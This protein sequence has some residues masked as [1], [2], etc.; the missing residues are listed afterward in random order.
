MLTYDISEKGHHPL[1]LY[2]YD[3][4]KSDIESGVLA[5]NE[6]LPSKRELAEHLGV[7]TITVQNAYAQ[8]LSEGHIYS[9][10]RSGY[11][12]SELEA[13]P[14]CAP[15][16]API[17]DDIIEPV[18]TST[19]EFLVDFCENSISAENFPFAVWATKMREVLS[20]QD[21]QLLKKIP[22][23]GVYNLRRAIADFLRRWRGMNLS[24]EQ[25]IIG[26]GT[27][28]LYGLLI[29][30][31][32]KDCTYAVEDPGYPTI[33][34]IYR[35]E[36]VECRFI[37][38]DESG[39][40]T[41]ALYSSDA[42]IVHISP[43]HHFPTGIVM[44][45][46]RRQEILK[47]ACNKQGRYIIEDDYDSE[48]RFVGKAIPTLQ[49]IDANGKVI[50]MNTFSKSISPA[51]RISYMVLPRPLLHKYR[52]LLGFYS[53]TV[54]SFEQYTLAKFIDGGYYERHINRM[55]RTYRLIR[56]SIIN[57]VRSGPL[58][59]RAEIFE[60]SSGLHFIMSIHTNVSD[61]ELTAKAKAKGVNLS[62]LSQYCKQKEN[63]AKSVIIINYSGVDINK[64]N[65]AMEIIS[66]II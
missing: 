53:C 36:D 34:E 63:A 56:D 14:A 3:C 51:I 26:A 46:K 49:S 30:L 32:G 42:D 50:Y 24:P 21:S 4:I 13:A 52:E 54:S 37:P 6:K 22:N 58:N 2:L 40:S 9:I 18:S 62:C 25:I 43:S 48:F 11:Y 1:Y 28:Y 64:V 59:N 45:I 23:A 15:H 61:E 66:K 8:L 38:L 57:T 16:S 10:E 44:P 35:A 55:R 17:I 29:K 47:W 41:S 27:E 12:V 33:S 39:M 31:L 65:N 20:E 19:P 60:E 7:S 5:S